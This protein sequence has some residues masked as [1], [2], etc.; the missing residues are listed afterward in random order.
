MMILLFPKRRLK[1]RQQQQAF[2]VVQWRLLFLVVVAL[3]CRNSTN[4]CHQYHVV[5]TAA[6]ATDTGSSSSSS[7]SSNIHSQQPEQQQHPDPN[8]EDYENMVYIGR[9]YDYDN[10]DVGG[11][12]NNDKMAEAQDGN[13][14]QQEQQ[15]SQQQQQRHQQQ[16]MGFD[17]DNTVRYL[18][19]TSFDEA[20]RTI[21]Q[22]ELA[23][24]PHHPDH[25]PHDIAQQQPDDVV[26]DKNNKQQQ[27]QQR[28]LLA[29][30]RRHDPAW[31]GQVPADGRPRPYGHVETNRL[32]GGVTPVKAVRVDP[33]F[34]DTAAVTNQEFAK[35]VAAVQYETEAEQYG[36][37]FVLASFLASSSN[38]SST[39]T[40]Q[41]QQ[42]Q[43]DEPTM[44]VDPEAEHWVAVQGAYWRQP[45]GPGSSYKYR[46][47]H[48]VVHVSHRDAAEYCH[49]KGKRLPGER[50]WEAAARWLHGGPTNR[51]LY[52]WGDPAML[53]VSSTNPT[54]DTNATMTTTNTNASELPLIDLDREWQTAAQYANLWGPDEFPWQN[55]GHDGWRGT[56]PVRYYKP[57]KA[58][59][60]DLTGNVWE[61]QRGGKHKARIVR[62]G[63]Y[64]DSLDGSFNHAATAGARAVIHG[65]TTT[66]NV[67][68]RCVKSPKR[69]VEHHW[70]W[71]DEE[72][73]GPLAVEDQCKCIYMYN[74]HVGLSFSG[75]VV[76]GNG[77]T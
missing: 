63:S 18:F 55:A 71:H 54:D 68:F 43:H 38:T 42:Q 9:L 7:S 3:F 35:F 24:L 31:H 25:P 40:Q 1:Q 19:G 73:H 12:D 47:Q 4:P 49:W 56:S 37:S 53:S 36:W 67:G 8:D 21:E 75:C 14:R 69:R 46:Q 11:D 13:G 59:I 72:E 44:E 16:R 51:T 41:Q 27:Q 32:D 50:E 77:T 28:T 22:A 74:I 34:I 10:D 52:I 6:A 20:H 76:S 15:Q 64:V 23:H 62:G 60:Y 26:H 65:T 70:T 66:G 30:Q 17:T 29:E 57:N 61:W 45:E 39:Q 33:F 5:A 48:P 58:G 2:T